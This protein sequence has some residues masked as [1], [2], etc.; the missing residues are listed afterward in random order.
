[1]KDESKILGVDRRR[2]IRLSAGGAVA[3]A[4]SGGVLGFFF[5]GYGLKLGSEDFPIALS[6]KEFAVAKAMV[7]ALLPEGDGFPSGDS[8]GIAQRIDEE[9]WATSASVRSDIKNG[10][11]LLEHAPSFQGFDGRF[12]SLS[13]AERQR[14]FLKCLTGDNALLRQLVVGFKQMTQFFYYAEP[15]VWP[16]IGYTGP[17]VPKALPHESHIAYRELLRQRQST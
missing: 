13:I 7:Q 9:A 10:L 14:F 4:A 16:M 17:F 5:A 1:V 11:Q 6:T 3:V 15:A 8:I 2:F 12:T